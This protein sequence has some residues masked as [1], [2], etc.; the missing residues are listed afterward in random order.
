MWG[1]ICSRSIGWNRKSKHISK[2]IYI[3]FIY[4][5]Y[6]KSAQWP[7]HPPRREVTF[8]PTHACWTKMEFLKL[9]SSSKATVKLPMVSLCGTQCD[10]SHYCLGRHTLNAECVFYLSETTLRRVKCVFYHTPRSPGAM[11][12]TNSWRLWHSRTNKIHYEAIHM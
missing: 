4:Y 2:Y 5:T 12:P 6:R 9:L 7:L 3:L 11:P 10:F 1:I 8:V